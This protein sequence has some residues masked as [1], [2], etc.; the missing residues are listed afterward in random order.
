MDNKKE[1]KLM[2][3]SIYR[4]YGPPEV[5]KIEEVERPIPKENEILVKVHA[6]SI[7]YADWAFVTGKP[8]FMRLF[9][10]VV[11]PREK[12]LGSDIA[13]TVEAVGLKTTKFNIG[14]EVFADLSDCGRGGRMRILLS[15]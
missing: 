5:L 10:G 8:I 7:Q 12:I 3:A 14:D 13:G 15:A 1:K 2:K 11:K 9:T 6:T 4:K